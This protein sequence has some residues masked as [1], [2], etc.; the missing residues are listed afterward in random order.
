[1]AAARTG[2]GT[3]LGTFREWWAPPVL[4]AVVSLGMLLG[5]PT[6]GSPDAPVNLA[7][8]WYDVHHGLP[9]NALVNV[10]GIQRP[11]FAFKPTLSAN[12]HTIGVIANFTSAS[13][14]IT[15]YPPPFQWLVGVGE[16]VVNT[17]SKT[18]VGDGGRVF[19]LLGCLAVLF[20]SAW[21]LRR[22]GER[23]AI[24]ALYLLSPP[25]ATFLYA[26]ANANGW[27]ICCALLLT[28]TLLYCKDELLSPTGSLR[29]L[30][31]VLV[32]GLALATARPSGEVWLLAI[33]AVFAIWTRAW[34]IRRS[35][36]ALAA[37]VAPGVAVAMAWTATHPLV[38][39][40][41]KPTFT[42]TIHNALGR[43][44][45]SAEDIGTRAVQLWGGLG[46]NDTMPSAIAVVGL[47]L[48]L[49]YYLPAYAPTLAHRRLLIGIVAIWFVSAAAWQAVSWQT[50]PP[51]YWWQER[52][53]L[54]LLGGLAMLLFSDPGRRVRP[55]LLALAAWVTVLNAYMV[56]MNFWRYDY[57]ITN[58]FPTAWHHA[59]YGAFHALLV[60]GV[61]L[62][63]VAIAVGLFLVD[64][65]QRADDAPQEQSSDDTDLSA[66]TLSQI[67]LLQT[68]GDLP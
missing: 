62:V 67:G 61:V 4:C 54:P 57:G 15:N 20:L 10:L 64:R 42:L 32:A 29:D 45:A 47:L 68:T 18:H 34:R 48:A 52:Y 63:L 56:A 53:S 33:A 24:W 6:F 26:G 60:Y 25:M 55:R 41:G 38:V 43:L 17:V 46:W 66:A 22:R 59:D 16:V 1:V 8:A 12:C 50:P 44:A 35:L 30:W 28:S 5:T 19:G 27:E 36:A 14:R 58:G 2:G 11:C 3:A 31:P 13:H 49:A 37:V 21:L 65:E 9:N 23:N 7:T 51:H 39:A 40:L